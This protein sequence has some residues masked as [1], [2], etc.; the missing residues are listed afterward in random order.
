MDVDTKENDI[1]N[2]TNLLKDSIASTSDEMAAATDANDKKPFPCFA[3]FEAISDHFPDKGS[4]D[5]LREKYIELTERIDPD[6][7]PECTPNIDGPKAESVSREQT[8]HSY[9]TLF[10]RRCF[11]YDCFLHRKYYIFLFTLNFNSFFFCVFRRL[12]HEKF[13]SILMKADS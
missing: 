3:I 8:L 7:P 6:R 5:E 13:F 1:D 2:K 10:C 4:A 11:K 12:F 9:H